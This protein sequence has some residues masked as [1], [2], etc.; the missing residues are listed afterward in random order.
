MANPTF[1]SL[2]LFQDIILPFILVFVLIYAILE[3]TKIFG[4][5]KHQINAILGVVIAGI[6]IAFSTQV[7]WIKQFVIFLVLALMILFV[8]MLIYGFAHAG[9][10]GFTMSR[11]LQVTIS[12]VAFIAVVIAVLV[13]TGNF[14][15]SF[16]FFTGTNIGANL[17]FGVLIAVV[18]VAAVLSGKK[19][20]ESK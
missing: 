1:L 17:V 10:E 12:V 6:L 4:E 19:K 13:I 15:K 3:R 7:D 16:N 9:N 5:D 18:I 2:P 8:F 14:G 11:K 20:S